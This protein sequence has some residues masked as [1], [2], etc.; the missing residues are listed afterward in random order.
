MTTTTYRGWQCQNCLSGM[1]QSRVCVFPFIPFRCHLMASELLLRSKRLKL[2][3]E[4]IWAHVQ[5]LRD[6]QEN[7]DRWSAFATLDPPHII[8]VN[9]GLFSE[10]LLAQSCLVP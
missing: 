10:G 7:F 5:S 3:K 4:F 2:Q 6:F 8:G 9:V 1:A